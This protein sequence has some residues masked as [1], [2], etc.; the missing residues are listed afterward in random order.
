MGWGQIEGML[1]P[2]SVF[3]R[4]RPQAQVD[5]RSHGSSMKY[6]AIVIGAGSAGAIVAGRLSED[7]HRSVLL[8][9]AGLDYRDFEQLPEE[10]KFGYGKDRNIWARAFGP[11]SKHDWNFVARATDQAGP[12]F[13]PRGKIV[14]GSSAVNAQIFLRGVPE[15]YDS[16]AAMGN[17]KWSFLELLPFFRRNEADA[18]FGDDFH[19]TDGPIIARRFNE[20]EWNPDQRAFYYACRA[21]GYSDC[22]DH[23]SPDSTGVGRLPLNN[24]NG[25]RWSTDIGYLSKARHR[26]NLTIRADCLVHRVLFEGKRAIGAT[27]ES[28]GEMFS[29]YGDEIVLSAGPIGSPH[30]LMLSG[31]GPADHLQSLDIPVLSDLPGVGQNLRD[32]P[33]VSVTLQT[34]EGFHQ[35][36]LEPRLQ[37]GLRY[38]ASG[39]HLRNDMFILPESFA[40]RDGYYVHS[41]SPPVGI[42]IVACIYLAVGSG[43]LRPTSVDPRVQPYL[44]YN[45]LQEAFDRERLREAVRLS[46]E[47]AE[48][49]EFSKIVQ[50]SVDPTDTDLESDETL[51]EWMMRKVQTSHHVSGTCKMGPS[52]DPL[53]V[54]D[55]HG[56]VHGIEGLR[57]ADAS[58]MPDCIRANT[59]VTAMVIGERVADFIRRGL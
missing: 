41:E 59:N 43:Q 32:H 50:Q 34:V 3:C 15:D 13:V 38:T 19:G 29:A 54:V 24:P 21:T 39:S 47:L 14:G 53:A 10:I 33:Q 17:D 6:D 55:Q 18:D 1:L 31:V 42:Y 8:L 52:S 27:V 57:V 56:K 28:G 4:I 23:N 22:P 40:T 5:R 46:V 26:V 49:E 45:F 9:E 48:R 11:G 37:V 58:I 25:V 2:V 12:M 36:G 35:D 16:W 7:P 30:T 20:E 44:D 51:D